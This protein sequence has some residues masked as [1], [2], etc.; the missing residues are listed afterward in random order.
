MK[1]T[2]TIRVK[3]Y[4]FDALSKEAQKKAVE[5]LADINTTFGDWYESVYEDA[6]EAGLRL[7]GFDLD[8]YKHATGEFIED[9]V[10]CAENILKNHSE[11]CETYKTALDFLKARNNFTED[12]DL[13]E[14]DEQFLKSILS[15][16]ANMLESEYEYLTGEESIIESIKANEYWFT[17]EGR[18]NPNK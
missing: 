8:R 15:D 17:K 12:Q 7:T 6:R 2:K 18:L 16:Y 10:T 9:A 14:R 3:L 1:L 4:Q 11:Q 13:E 5:R